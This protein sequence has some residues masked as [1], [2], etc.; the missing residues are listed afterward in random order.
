[1][2]G[3]DLYRA[4]QPPHPPA[5]YPPWTQGLFHPPVHLP[6]QWPRAPRAWGLHST[7]AWVLISVLL[8]ALS[9]L[10]S[11]AWAGIV[12]PGSI[13]GHLTAAPEV[14]LYLCPSHK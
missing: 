14:E 12:T 11:C 7:L 9:V 4:T 1:M 10:P 3:R 8:L 2:E 13:A 6:A 5:A